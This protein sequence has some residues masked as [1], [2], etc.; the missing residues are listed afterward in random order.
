MILSGLYNSA[1]SV[2]N[3]VK[4]RQLIRSSA[5]DTSK[6]LGGIGTAQM[7]HEIEERVMKI[8]K[9]KAE[10]IAQESGVDSSLTEDEMKDYLARGV[11]EVKMKAWQTDRRT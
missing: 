5:I 8:T 10:I 4:L 9:K 6:L 1:I 7:Q 3:D 11:E 2:A